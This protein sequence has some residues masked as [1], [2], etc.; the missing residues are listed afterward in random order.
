MD[1]TVKEILNRNSEKL[2]ILHLAPVSSDTLSS[3]LK[4]EEKAGGDFGGRK[5][6]SKNKPETR[7]N[8]V[9]E[10]A[11]EIYLNRQKNNLSGDSVSDWLLAETLLSIGSVY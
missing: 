9:K 8:T 11:Y 4:A 2:R 3:I 5:K 7:T 6:E 10:L 1:F